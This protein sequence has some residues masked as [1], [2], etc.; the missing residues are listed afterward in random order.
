[1]TTATM[2]RIAALLAAFAWSALIVG[3]SV[4]MSRQPYFD[5]KRVEV[6]GDLRHV[7]AASVRATLAGRLRGSFFTLQLEDARRLLETVPWVAHASVRRVW[8]NRLSVTLTEH[9]A[10]GVWHDGRLLSDRGELFVANADEAEVDGELPEFRGPAESAKDAARRF[11][12]LSARLSVLSLRVDAI[13][14]SERKSW[15]LRVSDMSSADESGETAARGR[16]TRIE[17]GRDLPAAP[18]SQRVD[19]VIAAYPLMVAQVGVPRHIDARY[20]ASFAVS[21]VKALPTKSGRATRP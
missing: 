12:D 14:I 13:D 21:P 4:W 8:P 18:L 3:V 15:S 6:R 5:L 7:N 19:K 9:R 10:L 2:N 20:A 1:M 17:L 16:D 11:Y